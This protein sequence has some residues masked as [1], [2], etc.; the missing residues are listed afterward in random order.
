MV[1]KEAEEQMIVC[2]LII[3]LSVTLTETVYALAET[4]NR[5]PV[6]G[7]HVPLF[8]LYSTFTLEIV[9]V[10]YSKKTI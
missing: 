9:S 7:V 2:N 5:V 8:I 1:E 4:V 3:T 6:Y 10:E